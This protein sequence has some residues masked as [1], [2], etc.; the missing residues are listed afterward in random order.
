MRSQAGLHRKIL[1]YN[2]SSEVT[3]AKESCTRNLH[4][5]W[6]WIML[7]WASYFSCTTFF[8]G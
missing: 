2:F 6:A 1:F 4:V 8:A 3:Y 7:C 5:S